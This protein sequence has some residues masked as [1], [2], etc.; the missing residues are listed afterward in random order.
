M[1]VAHSRLRLRPRSSPRLRSSPRRPPDRGRPRA[2]ARSAPGDREHARTPDVDGEPRAALGELIEASRVVRMRTGAEHATGLDDDRV[3]ALRR[4]LPRRADPE[5]A[6]PDAVVK[7]RQRSSQPSIDIDCGDVA[8]AARA[9][10]SPAVSVYAAARLRRQRR[11]PRSPQ[12]SGSS[13]LLRAL[14]PRSRERRPL[15]VSAEIAPS[16]G[17]AGRCRPRTSRRSR[18][19]QAPR[20]VPAARAWEH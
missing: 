4:L 2:P 13:T 9:L 1:R 12:G 8:E 11:A 7:A 6:R 17:R 3:H 15:S 5:G 20:G 18:S 10:A 16:S 19:R 14:P